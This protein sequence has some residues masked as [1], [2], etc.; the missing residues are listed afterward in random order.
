MWIIQLA[1]KNLW[2]NSSRTLI[3]IAAILFA[4]I[5]SIVAESLKAGVFDNLVKN[6]VSSYSGHIQIHLKGY[7][8]EQVLENGFYPNKAIE[9]TIKNKAGIKNMTDRLESF[10]LISSGEETKGCMILGINPV[11]EDSIS[12]LKKKIIQGV[13]L[14]A[15]DKGVLLAE[16]LA[17]KL[18]LSVNDTILLIGQ[19]YHGASAAAKTTIKGI[20]R[21]G[22]PKLNDRI[23]YMSLKEAQSFF[24]ADGLAT[25]Y[26][27]LLHE[28][29]DPEAVAA[30]IRKTI[31]EKYEV[32]TWGEMMPEIKQ[33]ITTDSNNMRIVQIILYILVSFG[34]FSTLLIMMAE[35]KSENGMLL[36]LGMSTFRLQLLI[37]TES[38]LTVM[39]GSIA[40]M[41][42]STPIV[43]YLKYNPI[44]IKGETAEAYKRFGFEPIFPASYESG[45]FL[46][47][48]LIVFI[49]GIILSMYPLFTIMRMNALNA[50]KK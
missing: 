20:I 36:A 19:G 30:S 16:G 22:S 41:V 42:L 40:G 5:I 2:R 25:A 9:A 31:G 28:G 4:T 13:Y 3:T 18:K 43:W 8:D 44:S 47:Q 11:Q 24:S 10:L 49:I 37:T 1:W 29:E 48:G 34:I 15:E 45:I 39:I 23:V 6:I 12:S 46:S 14:S 35:R 21:L 7:Q 17:K 33:H 26:I 27:L 38:L 50:M 32:L